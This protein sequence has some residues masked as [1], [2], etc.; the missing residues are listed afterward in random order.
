MKKSVPTVKGIAYICVKEEGKK[1]INKPR[2]KLV[3]L[4]TDKNDLPSFIE[5]LLCALGRVEE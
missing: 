2:E 5:L 3:F 4:Y 1:R